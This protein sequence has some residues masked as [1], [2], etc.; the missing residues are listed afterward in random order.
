LQSD[1]SKSDFAV[2]DSRDSDVLQIIA[3]NS[4]MCLQF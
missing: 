4:P 3:A 1:E 2:L